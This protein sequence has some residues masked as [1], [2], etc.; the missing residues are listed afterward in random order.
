MKIEAWLGA[1]AADAA[2]ARPSMTARAMTRELRLR[3]IGWLLVDFLGVSTLLGPV[4]SGVHHVS[5]AAFPQSPALQRA[6]VEPGPETDARVDRHA[7]RCRCDDP[8][9]ADLRNVAD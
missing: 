4:T 7:T 3:N 2:P 6:V 1:E 8:A 5:P 9:Q